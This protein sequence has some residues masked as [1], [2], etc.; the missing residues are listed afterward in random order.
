M[1][2]AEGNVFASYAY[3]PYGEGQVLNGPASGSSL[4]YQL[5]DVLQESLEG[6]TLG[7]L[8]PGKIR[9]QA[10]RPA[11]RQ[12]TALGRSLSPRSFF[13]TAPSNRTPAGP[14]LPLHSTLAGN[15]LT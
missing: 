11:T 14:T 7:D 4:A 2:D 3:G 15:S 13:P 1:A 9:V 5:D 8:I 12:P 6:Y 10:T